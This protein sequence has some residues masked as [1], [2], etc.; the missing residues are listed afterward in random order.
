MDAVFESTTGN[1]RTSSED[2]ALSPNV[3]KQWIAARVVSG[4]PMGAPSPDP[5]AEGTDL[6]P[7]MV[8]GF[9]L[10]PEERRHNERVQ[11]AMFKKS[12]RAERNLLPPHTFTK[13]TPPG[14]LDEKIPGLKQPSIFRRLRRFFSKQKYQIP[15]DPTKTYYNLE[16]INE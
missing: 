4:K 2:P 15:D 5:D 9:V 13:E 16:P 14:W 8:R 7:E 12:R 10:G 3:I 11:K 1:D 6:K